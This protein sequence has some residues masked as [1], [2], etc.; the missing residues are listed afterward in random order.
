MQSLAGLVPGMVV[1]L[2]L[3]IGAAV[4]AAGFHLIYRLSRRFRDWCESE[5]RK[6]PALYDEKEEQDG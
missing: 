5:M 4:V 1:I 2:G 3:L 6:C